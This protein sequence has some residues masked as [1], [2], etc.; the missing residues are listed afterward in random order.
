MKPC[1]PLLLLLAGC[2]PAIVRADEAAPSEAEQAARSSAVA[3]EEAFNTANSE[4]LAALWAE[5]AVYID[6]NGERT[7][8]RAALQERFK[9]QFE[10]N[11]GA[12]LTVFVESVQSVSDDVAVERGSASV[13]FDDGGVSEGPYTAVHVR[14]D[15][16]WQLASVHEY[17]APPSPAA[18]AMAPIAPLVGEW[19]FEGNGRRVE[20]V[21]RWALNNNFVNRTFTLYVGDEVR[22]RGV[23]MVGWDAAAGEVRA[24]TFLSDGTYSTTGWTDTPDGWVQ[25]ALDGTETEIGATPI[26]ALVALENPPSAP[27]GPGAADSPLGQLVWMAGEWVDQ[28]EDAVVL[29]RCR[30]AAD[31]RFLARK[32]TAYVGDALST[33]GI[34]IVGYDP[35]AQGFR[36]WV[37][38]SDGGHAEGVWKADGD[39]R[40]TIKVAGVLA[41]GGQSSAVQTIEKLDDDSML[42]EAVS[43]EVDG[44]L[45][46]S[47]GP[48]LLVRIGA[49]A[50]GGATDAASDVGNGK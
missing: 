23:E 40:W 36:S 46:P 42:F 34:Q 20:T 26:A 35:E 9:T 15:G 21:A 38:D 44:R 48:L 39:N 6:E 25:V 32:F 13:E 28:D 5:D 43:R 27:P 30:L 3:Y 2:W 4:A 11:P 31:G 47:V 29:T 24:W 16:T 49:A 10:S 18:E 37:F 8:G 17:I 41:D 14:R 1:V 12:L 19:T 50:E 45:L 22:L 7:E 33:E